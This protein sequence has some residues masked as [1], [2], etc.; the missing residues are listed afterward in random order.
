MGA[1]NACRFATAAGTD[2]LLDRNFAPPSGCLWPDPVDF[3]Q[4]ICCML[5]YRRFVHYAFQQAILF[6]GLYEWMDCSGSKDALTQ[7]NSGINTQA[8]L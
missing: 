8:I 6:T 7:V 5:E 4:G 3:S 1:G 2:H